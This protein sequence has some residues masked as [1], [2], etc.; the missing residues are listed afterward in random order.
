MGLTRQKR[1]PI[2]GVCPGPFP[3][4]LS[5]MGRVDN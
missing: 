5:L 4:L 3:K 2:G 1:H